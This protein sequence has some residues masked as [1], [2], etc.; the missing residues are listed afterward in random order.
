MH[1]LKHHAK[2]M[3]VVMPMYNLMEY[4]NNYWKTSRNFCQCCKDEPV[5]IDDGTI[6]SLVI[7]PR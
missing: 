5:L 3:D 1:H 7:P 4:S 2:Y 6:E